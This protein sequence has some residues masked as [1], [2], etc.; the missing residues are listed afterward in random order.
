M[1]TEKNV[2]ISIFLRWKPAIMY[3][4]KIDMALSLKEI[5]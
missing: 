3:K 1:I 5:Y 4:K 2:G